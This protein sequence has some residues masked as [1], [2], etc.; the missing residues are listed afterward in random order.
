LSG[1]IANLAA[2]KPTL[3]LYPVPEVG[4]TPSRLDLDA[5]AAGN[6]PPAVI[7]TSW[8]RFKE[9]NAAAVHILNAIDAP[10]LLRSQ[11]EELLCNTMLKNRCV[12]QFNG[13]LYYADDDHLSMQG[14]RMVID[15][16]MRK[17][18]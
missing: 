2:L 17:L 7:S 18:R 1:Y 13:A 10:N 11:P 14:A 9:R 16:V 8:L 6:R 4:W 5:I 3:I 15:D 12:A